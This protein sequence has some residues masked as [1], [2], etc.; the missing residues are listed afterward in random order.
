MEKGWAYREPLLQIWLGHRVQR[1]E[2]RGVGRLVHFGFTLKILHQVGID[3]N[4]VGQG[5]GACNL[6]Q[7]VT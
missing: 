6:G 4:L 2:E 1:V 5:I 3:V 7:F